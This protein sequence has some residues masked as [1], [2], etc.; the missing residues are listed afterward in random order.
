MGL[1]LGFRFQVKVWV[2]GQDLGVSE[3]LATP[4]MQRS[5]YCLFI[6]LVMNDP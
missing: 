5:L 3:N 2:W 1:D 6:D 4:Q